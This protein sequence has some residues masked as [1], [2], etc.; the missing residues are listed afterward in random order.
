MADVN[1]LTKLNREQ[2]NEF[3]KQNGIEDADN[4]EKYVT[5][6]DLAEALSS[7]VTPEQLDAFKSGGEDKQEEPENP[8]PEQLD[9]PPVDSPDDVDDDSGEEQLPTRTED[10]DEPAEPQTVA[11]GPLMST[12]G[13][14]Y[15]L[16]KEGKTLSVFSNKVHE[17]VR[18]VSGHMV[19]MTREEYDT[20]TDAEV[21]EKLKKLGKL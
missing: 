7:K 17:T 20:K 12:P 3:A 2:L 13:M 14:G 1:D 16:N 6:K 15:K 8:E 4:E 19:P 9:T 21:I 18:F 10:D 5:K 11:G